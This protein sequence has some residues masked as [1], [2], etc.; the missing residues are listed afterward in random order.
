MTT[1]TLAVS[2][3]RDFHSQGCLVMSEERNRNLKE[4]LGKHP[5][6]R[7]CGIILPSMCDIVWVENIRLCHRNSDY[8]RDQWGLRLF[9]KGFCGDGS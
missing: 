5:V 6:S 9:W 2:E 8:G 4:F 3:L 7:A 1:R